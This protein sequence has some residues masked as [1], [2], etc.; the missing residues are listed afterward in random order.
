MVG[1]G[2]VLATVFA[3]AHVSISEDVKPLMRRGAF[4]GL[5]FALRDSRQKSSFLPTLDGTKSS[6]GFKAEG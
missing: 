6:L 1:N 3:S 2:A 5:D 4:K